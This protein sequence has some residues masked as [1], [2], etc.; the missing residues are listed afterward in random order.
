MPSLSAG[1]LADCLLQKLGAVERSGRHRRFD[2]FDDRGRL[3]ASTVMSHSWRRNTTLS[4]GMV[5]NIK[6]QLHLARAAELL[7]LVDCTLS[8]EQYLLLF[9]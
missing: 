7:Q 2:V 4:A 8:R 5:S 3:V 1:D 6:S 9:P